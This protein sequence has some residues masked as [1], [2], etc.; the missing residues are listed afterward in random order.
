MMLFFKNEK[1]IGSENEKHLHWFLS[2]H[3]IFSTVFDYH[4]I[5]INRNAALTWGKKRLQ[6]QGLAFNECI[7]IIVP[8]L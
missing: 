6:K 5:K 8:L 3:A 7:G 1:T 2:E 4:S